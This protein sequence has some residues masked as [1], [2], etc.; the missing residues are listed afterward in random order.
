[1]ILRGDTFERTKLNSKGKE[2]NVG[3]EDLVTILKSAAF[4]NESEQSENM[5]RAEHFMFK[6]FKPTYLYASGWT[7]LLNMSTSPNPKTQE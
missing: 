3:I 6:S 7:S 5:S 4:P 2:V 1:M